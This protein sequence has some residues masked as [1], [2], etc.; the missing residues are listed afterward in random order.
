[1]GLV[2]LP[3]VSKFKLKFSFEHKDVQSEWLWKSELHT[4]L[5]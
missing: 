5:A 3:D 1:M 4:W 2:F